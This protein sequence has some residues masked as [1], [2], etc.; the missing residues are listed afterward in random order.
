M[1]GRIEYRESGG[2][3]GGSGKLC[4]TMT[5]ESGTPAG[6][7]RRWSL[8]IATA[9]RLSPRFGARTVAIPVR[10]AESLDGDAVHEPD[11]GTRPGEGVPG[12]ALGFLAEGLGI[13]DVVLEVARLGGVDAEDAHAATPVSASVWSATTAAEKAPCWG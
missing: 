12:E 7:Q 3:A 1:G 5:N 13:G 4:T 2:W 8:G 11:A 9:H 6:A 10:R